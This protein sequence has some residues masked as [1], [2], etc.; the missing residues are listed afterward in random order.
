MRS[1]S[2]S[3]ILGIWERGLAQSQIN[4][5][6]ALL[7]LACPE[8]SSE[9]LAKL[10]IGKRDGIILTL[11]EQIFGPKLVC[12]TACPSCSERLEMTLNVEDIQ[13]KPSDHDAELKIGIDDIEVKF[14]LPNSLDLIAIEDNQD[15]SRVRQILI[16]RCIIE[17]CQNGGKMPVDQLPVKI[18]EAIEEKMAEAD[19]QAN[20][21][22]DL[23]CPACGNKWRTAF[24]IVSFFWNE[25]NAW[26]QRVLQEVHVLAS[27][28]GWSEEEI[29]GMSSWRRQ[30]YLDLVSQ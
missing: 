28:Y 20:V 25:I 4:R 12:L 7:A 1:I 26:A 19:P 6:L 29:L 13:T 22:L 15:M 16:E 9:E 18:I 23:T 30:V 2:S 8:A 27:A 24:D 11:H 17:V 5:G 14:R 10:P 3:E 21:P